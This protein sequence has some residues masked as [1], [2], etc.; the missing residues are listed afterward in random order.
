MVPENGISKHR[1][2]KSKNKC[3]SEETQVGE[4]QL[5]DKERCI[6]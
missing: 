4:R 5:V 6:A 2:S 1:T 3:V